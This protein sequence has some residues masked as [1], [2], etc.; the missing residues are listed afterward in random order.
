MPDTL[1]NIALIVRREY[2]QRLRTRAFW[3]MTL[4]I[5]GMMI[6]FTSLPGKFMTMKVGGVQR[7]T[8]VSDDP[9]LAADFKEQFIAK[10]VDDSQQYTVEIVNTSEAE[11]QRLKKE[12]A[13]K[14]LDGVVWLTKDAV[15]AGKISY[16]T[17]STTD[18]VV[19]ERISRAL[20][21]AV[22]RQ[23]V[24]GAG[25]SHVDLDSLLK[26]V[27]LDAIPVEAGKAG[28]MA[29]FYVTLLLVMILYMTV[30]VHGVGVMRSVLE[31]KTSRVLEVML[32]T[33]T[34]KELMAGKMIG[35]GAVGLTQIAIWALGGAVYGGTAIATARALGQDIHLSPMIGVYFALFFVLGFL[36]YSSISA[37]VGAMATSEEE[38]QQLSFIVVLPIVIAIMFMFM[39]F[40]APSSPI[41]VALSLVPFFAPILMF[42]RI[43][44]ETP[45]P[46]QIAL[47]LALMVTTIYIVL[48]ICA[49]IYRV[50]ILMYGKRPTLP[51]II[52]WVKYA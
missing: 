18:F 39:V 30:I 1:R 38:A 42:M 27:Q 28:G 47:C 8:V 2:L 37:A 21:R 24:A 32:A 46:W 6:G 45:P 26:Q 36:L 15:A 25:V 20:F 43:M 50:G 34:P 17:R 9:Q 12:V 33:V 35:V 52:K 41:S 3:V 23:R 14:Q 5:P 13:D 22:V 48:S 16:Y 49:R 44:V 7:I 29:W 40:R 31:E 10:H 19:Q 51:E 11:Q 4:L